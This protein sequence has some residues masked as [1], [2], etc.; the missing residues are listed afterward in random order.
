MKLSLAAAAAAV[1]VAALADVEGH[2]H[3]LRVHILMEKANMYEQCE[4]EDKA[5]KCNTGMFC[6]E[7][8]QHFGWCLKQSPGEGEQC[9]G[10]QTSGP[11]AVACNG[12]DLKCVLI[13]SQ[14]SQCQKKTNRE[15]LKMPKQVKHKHKD[16]HEDKVALYGRC[17]YQDGSKS[18]AGGLQCIEDNEWSGSCLKKEA[19]LYEQCGGKEWRGPWKASCAKG[20]HL[21][22]DSV[23]M[24]RASVGV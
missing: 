18:C 7:R 19:E 14:F 6:V 16:G 5:V 17:K 2:T 21:H 13:S 9:G 4:W 15:K 20:A 1:A 22:L 11:W 12:S 3:H 23:F 8:E 24:Q 10:A